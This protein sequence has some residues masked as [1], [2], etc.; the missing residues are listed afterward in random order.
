M[1][2]YWTQADTRNAILTSL[3]PGGVAL[4]GFGAIYRDKSTQK[5]LEVSRCIEANEN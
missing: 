3:I 5:W 4:A 1:P 2:Y